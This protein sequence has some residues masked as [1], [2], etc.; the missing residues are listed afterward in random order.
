MQPSHAGDCKGLVIHLHYLDDVARKRNLATCQEV[1]VTRTNEGMSESL[2]MQ[3]LQRYCITVLSGSDYYARD[4]VTRRL[5][6]ESL[7]P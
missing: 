6:Q 2:K 1:S 7:S 3:R 5:R 4:R